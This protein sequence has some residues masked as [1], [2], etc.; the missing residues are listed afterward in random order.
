MIKPKKINP[1]RYEKYFDIDE[2]VVLKKFLKNVEYVDG[3]SE[4]FKEI[5]LNEHQMLI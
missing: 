3:F 5:V 2:L 1:T 4:K